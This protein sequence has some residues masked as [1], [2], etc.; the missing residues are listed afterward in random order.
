VLISYVRFDLATIPRSTYFRDT[1]VDRATLSLLAQSFGLANEEERFLVS[2]TPCFE[3]WAEDQMTWDT[4]VCQTPL[5]ADDMIVLDYATLPSLARWDVT[6]SVGRAVREGRKVTFV[7][8][9][10]KL[11]RGLAGARDII[12]D[13]KI[14]P[15]VG[16]G[17]V[18]FWS[19]KRVA[20]SATAAPT[21]TIAYSQPDARLTQ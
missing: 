10:V 9:A 20:L 2:A 17:F 11:Q 12:P 5:G 8:N 15:E 18:R 4:R 19:R 16:M 6:H 21:L 1:V 13:E 14:G 3:N 7:I